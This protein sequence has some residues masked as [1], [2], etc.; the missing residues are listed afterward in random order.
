MGAFSLLDPFPHDPEGIIPRH[1]VYGVKSHHIAH[2]NAGID[3]A[4]D[5]LRRYGARTDEKICSFRL[6][7]AFVGRSSGISR[8]DLLSS[9]RG[10]TV[11]K[12]TLEDAVTDQHRRLRGHAF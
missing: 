8:R 9:P 3:P 4:D 5:V 6:R 12:K 2:I 1:G 7:E 11:V 10:R